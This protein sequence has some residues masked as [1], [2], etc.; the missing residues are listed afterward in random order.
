[1]LAH[2]NRSPA[3]IRRR[4]VR[5]WLGVTK[6]CDGSVR[7]AL[8]ALQSVCERQ[9]GAALA[10][11]V[12]TECG[13]CGYVFHVKP[14]LGSSRSVSS[15]PHSS[16]HRSPRPRQATQLLAGVS[17]LNGERPRAQ[18]S[19]PLQ[20]NCFKPPTLIPR[21]PAHEEG[22]RHSWARVSLSTTG[23]H[24]QPAGSNSTDPIDQTFLSAGAHLST[25][26]APN[27]SPASSPRESSIAWSRGDF[28]TTGHCLPNA[29]QVSE[30]TARSGK[31]REPNA[32]HARFSGTPQLRPSSHLKPG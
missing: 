5:S 7:R 13:C 15:T 2:L 24:P 30:W 11:V 4:A 20:S 1:L 21:S 17:R 29:P 25:A 23:Q 8:S 32:E 10:L 31:W 16:E 26:P 18:A 28:S 22:A 19:L 6:G 12:R 3:W 14:A 9:S 27:L